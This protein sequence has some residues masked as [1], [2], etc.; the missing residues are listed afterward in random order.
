[1]ATPQLL[2]A[3]NSTSA[4][5]DMYCV[6]LIYAVLSCPAVNFMSPMARYSYAIGSG[7]DGS[8][9]Q[10]E[11][12]LLVREAHK[13]GIEVWAISTAWRCWR[14]SSVN[15]GWVV[16]GAVIPAEF[17][18]AQYTA[19]APAAAAGAVKSRCMPQLSFNAHD[20]HISRCSGRRSWCGCVC[21]RLV[22]VS[23]DP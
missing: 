7:A 5:A 3:L 19:A 12:K 16:F 11:F 13:R 9:L 21:L 2:E 22:C 17:Q 6:L 14:S 15:S 1:M 23:G 8:A 4:A 18:T 10:Q 20:N